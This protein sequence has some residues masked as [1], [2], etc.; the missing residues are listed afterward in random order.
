MKNN[1]GVKFVS[2]VVLLI[3]FTFA[4]SVSAGTVSSFFPEEEGVDFNDLALKKAD[5][6]TSVS[7]IINY[8]LTFLGTVSLVLIVYSGARWM[9]A[10]GNEEEIKKSQEILKGGVIGLVIILSSYALSYFVFTSLVDIVAGAE[11][12]D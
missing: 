4:F 2:F 9:L 8:A 3:I 5:V 11:L 7:L 1:F 10:R 6:F 12:P